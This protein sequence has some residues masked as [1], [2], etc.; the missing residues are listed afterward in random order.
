MME[1]QL[2]ASDDDQEQLLDP[3]QL[4]GY[5]GEL[6]LANMKEGNLAQNEHNCPKNKRLLKICHFWP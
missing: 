2:Q 4:P 6:T 3:R 1:Q 5:K